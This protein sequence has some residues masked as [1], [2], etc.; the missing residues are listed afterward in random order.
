MRLDVRDEEQ[1][2]S[3]IAEAIKRFGR[4]DIVVNNAGITF[5]NFFS[6]CTMEDYNRVFDINS[7][8]VF[9][10]CKYAVI[11]MSPG[12]ASGHGGSIINISSICA[13]IGIPTIEIY[14]AAKGAVRGLTR[15]LAVECAKL[16]TGIRVNAIY[17]GVVW[18]DMGPL[19][20][21]RAFELGLMPDI[22]TAETAYREAHP[23]GCYGEAFDIACAVLYLASDASKWVTGIE[24]SV[25]GGL[26]AV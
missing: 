4:L 7:A 25:D 20:A 9:L 12:G 16:K 21:K 1:W 13:L 11:A 8:G 3:S 5:Q 10:G 6:K 2:K 26:Y 19:L 17:P 24:L 14:S 23:L 15:S 18:T 22:A